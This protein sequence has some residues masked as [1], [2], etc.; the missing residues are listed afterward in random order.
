ML[1][2]GSLWR[3]FAPGLLKNKHDCVNLH[4]SQ[5]THTNLLEEIGHYST[6]AVRPRPR[7][8]LVAECGRHDVVLAIARSLVRAALAVVV[9]RKSE[10]VREF[11]RDRE[12]GAQSVVLNDRTAAKRIADGSDLSKTYTRA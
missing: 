12:R 9:M 5:E 11:V 4:K 7:V 6:A 3:Q 8:G 1:E 10:H 2:G